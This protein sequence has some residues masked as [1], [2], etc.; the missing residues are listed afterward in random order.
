MAVYLHGSS[1]VRSRDPEKVSYTMAKST[2][3]G[4]RNRIR[5]RVDKIE[6]VVRNS[7]RNR[8]MSKGKMAAAAGAA[9]AGA[10][11]LFA[12][13]RRSGDGS[14]GDGDTKTNGVTLHVLAEDEGWVLKTEGA[15]EG[16]SFSTKRKAIAAGREQ[17]S[18]SAPS[19]L[20]IHRKDGTVELSHAYGE[21]E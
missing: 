5:K 16:E 20:V 7:R 13:S 4:V 19:N 6:G 17:A 1:H 14:T 18:T 3:R 10:A 2:R 9:V 12:R 11:A 8:G 15:D 21:T